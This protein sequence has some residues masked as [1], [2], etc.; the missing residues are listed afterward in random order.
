[1]SSI[2]LTA[3]SGGGTVELKGPASTPSNGARTILLPNGPGMVTQV[4]QTVLTGVV[5][6]T[7]TAHT[8][9][10]ITGY[11]AS[12]TPSTNSKVLVMMDGYFSTESGSYSVWT[13]LLRGSTAIGIGDQ[14]GSNRQRVGA[15][16]WSDPDGTYDYWVNHLTQT[17]LDESPGGNGSTAITYKVQWADGYGKNLHLNTTFN[18][19]DQAPNAT[20][21]STLTLMEIAG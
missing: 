8:P 13:R 15:F 20:M 12:I 19:T 6:S 14:V 3:D 2:K 7:V 16:G 11:S 4:V 1:M 5:T 10:D 9:E 21:V 17:F 18:A